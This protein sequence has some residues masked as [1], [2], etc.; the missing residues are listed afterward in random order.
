M[1]MVAPSLAVVMA[2]FGI[3][4]AWVRQ[5]RQLESRCTQQNSYCAKHARWFRHLFPLFTERLQAEA[6]PPAESSGRRAQASRCLIL[7]Q[8]GTDSS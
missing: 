6:F 4:A 7:L 8:S 5:S 2:A 1:A 3:K